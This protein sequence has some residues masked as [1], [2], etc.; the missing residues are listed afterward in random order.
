[1]WMIYRHHWIII[2]L[3]RL[4]TT[5]SPPLK[6]IIKVINKNSQNFFA[7]Q[8]LKTIGLEKNGFGSVDNGVKAESKLFKEMG[9]NP[10][11]MI[12][13]DGSGFPDLIL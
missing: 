12:L 10:E 1:M 9:I 2:K 4:C 8:L 7:E 11:S 13:V 3:K 6:E 5:Y